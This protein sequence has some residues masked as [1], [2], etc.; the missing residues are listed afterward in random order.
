MLRPWP[1]D[2]PRWPSSASAV[3][4]DW[5]PSDCSVSLAGYNTTRNLASV[6]PRWSAFAVN[7]EQATGGQARGYGL[8]AVLPTSTRTASPGR[9]QELLAGVRGAHRRH[10]P[11]GAQATA[12]Y[13]E[14][15]FGGPR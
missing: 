8:L 9:M 6:S 3:F 12:R 11:G 7:R 14:A 4:S 5:W 13:I 15:N 1:A 2:G 10:R